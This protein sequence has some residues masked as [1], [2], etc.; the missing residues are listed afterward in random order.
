[1]LPRGE[2]LTKSEFARVFE[3]GRNFKGALFQLRVLQRAQTAVAGGDASLGAQDITPEVEAVRAAF[4]AGKK[5][6]KAVVRNGLRRRVREIYRLSRWRSEPTLRG[7]D[8][9]FMMSPAALAA[10]REELQQ[11]LDDLL[12]R[13]KR[14]NVRT[15]G[16]GA[17]AENS[18]DRQ[19]HP[20]G[21]RQSGGRTV[22]RVWK[23]PGVQND[24]I[25]RRAGSER[26]PAGDTQRG[27]TGGGDAV[28]GDTE[29]G[30]TAGERGRAGAE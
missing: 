22:K 4:V 26:T 18:G 27:E 8:L 11:A 13:A 7:C 9:V 5:L 1:M 25:S 20:A 29:F 3:A 2:R 15:R 30:D 23:Q 12:E 28:S 21:H 10:S 17:G 14:E 24:G 16:R 19:G 6:G